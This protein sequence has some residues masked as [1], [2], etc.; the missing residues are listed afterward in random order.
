[1]KTVNVPLLV[2]VN[3][4]VEP[5]LITKHGVTEDVYLMFETEWRGEPAVIEMRAH[6][7]ESYWSDRLNMGEWNITGKDSWLGSHGGDRHPCTGT[8]QLRMGDEVRPLVS[9]WLLSDDYACSESAAYANGIKAMLREFRS[10]NTD[11]A[12][13]R[14]LVNQYQFKLTFEQTNNLNELFDAWDNYVRLHDTTRFQ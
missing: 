12:L 4:Y 14:R 8:A 13:L 6:R 7:N 9:L 2:N 5:S 10:R 1:M 11:S 3:H